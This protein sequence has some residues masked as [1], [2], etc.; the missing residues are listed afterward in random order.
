MPDFD[1]TT[2]ARSVRTCARSM[3]R[4]AKRTTSS[5]GWGRSTPGT[6][7]RPGSGSPRN[8]RPTDARCFARAMGG[9]TRAC[10]RESSRRSTLVRRPPPRRISI[11]RRV[12]TPGSSP[13]SIP[14]GTCSSIPRP[15]HHERMSIRSGWIGRSG[16]ASR[17]R[18]CPQPSRGPRLRDRARAAASRQPSAVAYS[19]TASSQQK[20]L[21]S[22][23]TATAT[24]P[25]RSPRPSLRVCQRR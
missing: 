23:A 16:A 6:S 11:P 15:A 18:G 10:S 20:W 3:R 7:G 17:W 14:G 21:S 13:S 1:S 8:S 22:R 5:V 2:A 19:P 12:I 4:A 24:T 9:S 25:P